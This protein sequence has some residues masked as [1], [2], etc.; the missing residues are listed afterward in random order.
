M[1]RRRQTERE[2][3]DCCQPEQGFTLVEMMLALMILVFGITAVANSMLTGIGLRRGTEM[4]FRAT[5][6]V[7]QAVHRIQEVEFPRYADP[8]ESL[9]GFTVEDPPGYPG[10]KYIVEYVTDQ[11][12]P[13]VVLAKI[14]VS[15][16]EQGQNVGETFRR[17]LIRRAD[18][19]AF[20][21]NSRDRRPCAP[22]R[23]DVDEILSGMRKRGS[24]A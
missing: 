24:R 10:M 19:S 14:Q 9:Q 20:V 18:L 23:V 2:R 8:S 13:G 12:Q 4:R 21:E 3:T 16:R 15:W 11:E 7:T 22:T 1:A 5:A 6:L 17:I